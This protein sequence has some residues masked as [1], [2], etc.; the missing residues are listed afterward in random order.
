MIKSMKPLLGA[1]TLLI[2]AAGC[3]MSPSQESEL[4]HLYDYRWI[5]PA[6]PEGGI[7]TVQAATEL[8]DYDVIFFGELHNHP[9]IHL[10]Q[11]ELLAQLYGHNRPISLSLEQFERD[12]QPL[13]DQYLARE[14]GEEYLIQ[15]ARAWDHYRSSY[16]P[17]VEFARDHQLLVIAA[18]APNQMVICVGR[19]GLEVL[20]KYPVEQRRHVAQRI[21]VEDG[22]YRQKFLDFMHK[23]SAH[24]LPA[25]SNSQKTMQTMMQRSFAA[26]AVRDD[27]MAE[28]IARHLRQNPG[29]QV[30]HLNGNFHSSDFL[31]TVER[32]QQRIPELNIAVI[33]PMTETDNETIQISQPPGTLLIQVKGIPES[34][35]KPQHRDQWLRN[36]MTKRMESREN[37]PQ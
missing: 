26:Q 18:N 17:L 2:L 34:F 6:E 30:L 27:T 25:D 19:F 32:L 13:L 36:M 24:T 29:R 16:R 33:H 31:G 23:D 9:G 5:L 22:A 35:V 21:D 8:K 28:S 12:T 4:V 7:T 20:D 37:C 14:I 15:E 11:M 10:A 3:S 1:V